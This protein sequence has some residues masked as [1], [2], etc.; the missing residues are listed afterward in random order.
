MGDGKDH[1]SIE[2]ALGE[3][4]TLSRRQ[5][6]AVRVGNW[7]G[8]ALLTASRLQVEAAIPG[9]A[10]MP[11]AA[12]ITE[13]AAVAESVA[14]AEEI[15][16]TDRE[17]AAL[18]GDIQQRHSDELVKTSRGLAAQRGY[19]RATGGSAAVPR[20]IDKRS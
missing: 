9:A 14:V 15:M 8:L 16:A 19:A 1:C 11:G 12:E 10:G 5:L 2:E 4:L 20:Y 3:L 13:T 6:E 7:E 17:T 18:L